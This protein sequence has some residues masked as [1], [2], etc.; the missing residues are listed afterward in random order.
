M[1]LELESNAS[2]SVS[3]AECTVQYHVLQSVNAGFLYVVPD[4]GRNFLGGGNSVVAEESRQMTFGTSSF[5]RPFSLADTTICDVGIV[6]GMI[7]I[8]EGRDGHISLFET[9]LD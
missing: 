7:S 2:C 3:D 5:L 8:R 1:G 6:N 4:I 9:Q